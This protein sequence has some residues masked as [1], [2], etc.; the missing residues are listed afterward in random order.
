MDASVTVQSM[1]TAGEL[2]DSLRGM[3]ARIQRK[4][5]EEKAP[6]KAQANPPQQPTPQR[7]DPE[8][9]PGPAED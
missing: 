6:E 4:L 9:S 8:R 2:A 7:P 3:M 1:E 5:D